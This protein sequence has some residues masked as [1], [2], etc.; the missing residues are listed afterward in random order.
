M[1]GITQSE[2]AMDNFELWAEYIRLLEAANDETRTL[3]QHE[4]ALCTLRAWLSGVH[5]ATGKCFNGDY[6]YIALG[7]DRPMCIGQF[8][9]WKENK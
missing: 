4:D 8:L 7:V 9:D 2:R 5:A 1:R 3:R 6:H